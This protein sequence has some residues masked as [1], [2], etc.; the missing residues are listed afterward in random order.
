MNIVTKKSVSVLLAIFFFAYIVIYMCIDDLHDG[1]FINTVRLIPSFF[2]FFAGLYTVNVFGMKSSRG[3]AFAFLTAGILCWLVRDIAWVGMHSHAE[4]FSF[5]RI[6]DIIHLLGYILFAIG[7]YIEYKNGKVVWNLKKVLMFLFLLVVLVYFVFGHGMLHIYDETNGLIDNLFFLAFGLGEI[8]LVLL[9]ALI[10][11]IAF[12]YRKGKMFI[13]WIFIFWG[14]V[15]NI[16]GHILFDM[17]YE[18]Y[19]GGMKFF[20]YISMFWLVFYE[21]WFYGIILIGIE[22]KTIQ[23]KAKHLKDK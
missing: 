4:A 20:Q 21:F 19:E 8:I 2:A 1:L 9:C 3:R 22:I 7:F 6:I 10:L 12:E 5:T 15:F 23:D 14:L 17:F 16:V 11:M 18:Y 13:P